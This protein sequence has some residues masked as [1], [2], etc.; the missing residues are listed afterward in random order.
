MYAFFKCLYCARKFK[1]RGLR[2]VFTSSQY[3]NECDRRNENY[4]Y[5]LKL[6]PPIYTKR[7]QTHV[8]A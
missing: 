8:C 2:Y 3:I 5:E 4:F 1:R 7:T 6:K